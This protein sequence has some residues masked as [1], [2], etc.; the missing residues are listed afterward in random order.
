MVA[1]SEAR[2]A[3][4]VRTFCLAENETE[5]GRQERRAKH[6]REWED[7]EARPA[8]DEPYSSRT[9]TS[10]N[11]QFGLVAWQVE[12]PGEHKHFNHHCLHIRIVETDGDNERGKHVHQGGTGEKRDE[13]RSSCMQSHGGEGR[14]NSDKLVGAGNVLLGGCG[15]GVNDVLNRA[16]HLT[17]GNG[18]NLHKRTSMP[19]RQ[20]NGQHE[21]Q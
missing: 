5:S 11:T 10:T 9:R 12:N 21:G 18:G 19:V 20:M 13:E 17:T 8:R 6:V 16:L 15:N 3:W 4:A 2:N 14:T 1:I 7:I